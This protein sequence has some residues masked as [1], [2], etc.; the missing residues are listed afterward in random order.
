MAYSPINRT[1]SPQGFSLIKILHKLNT[2]Q[3]FI[4]LFIEGLYTVAKSTAQGHLRS[5][6]NFKSHTG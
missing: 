6:H 5:I 3:L 1:G 2:T 4:D